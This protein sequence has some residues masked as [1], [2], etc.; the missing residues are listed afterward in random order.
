MTAESSPVT[1][2]GVAG[3]CRISSSFAAIDVRGVDGGLEV[4]GESAK[5]AIADVKKD[6]SL[7]SSFEAIEARRVGGRLTVAAE[8]ADRLHTNLVVDGARASWRRP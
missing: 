1:G 2:S 6:A 5:V 3:D 8:S 4:N 7:R